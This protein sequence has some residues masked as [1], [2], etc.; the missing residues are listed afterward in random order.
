MSNIYIYMYIHRFFL[1]L[2]VFIQKLVCVHMHLYVHTE[3]SKHIE[4]QL[5]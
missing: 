1:Y 3:A 5:L 4:V 2:S